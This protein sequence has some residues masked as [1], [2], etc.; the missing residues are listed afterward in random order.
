M[1]YYYIMEYYDLK[2]KIIVL[3][4][5]AVLFSKRDLENFQLFLKQTE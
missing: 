1:E 3:R 4:F 5:F 2:N